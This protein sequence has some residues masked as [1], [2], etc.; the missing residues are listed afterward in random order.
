MTVVCAWITNAAGQI[1]LSQR[2]RGTHLAGLWEFPGG[3]VENDESLP[4]ALRRELKEELDIDADVGD[5]ISAITH[6]YPERRVRLHLLTVRS[7]DGEP[8]ARDV[9]ALKWVGAD[10]F[11]HN[12]SS[13]PDAD[14]PLIS[15]ALSWKSGA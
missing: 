14:R 15:A 13:M 5:E 10:W 2:K 1:L 9:A 3:K 8:K 7:Y 11:A 6:D 4:A 12:L